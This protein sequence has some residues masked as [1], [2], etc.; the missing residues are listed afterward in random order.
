MIA[1]DVNWSSDD[2]LVATIHDG[3]VVAVGS[4][5]T[6]VYGEYQGVKLSCIVR[7]AESVGKA[8]EGISG[9]GDISESGGSATGGSATGG[10]SIS[11]VDVSIKV[12]EKFSLELKDANGIAVSVNW[13]VVDGSVCS[14]SGNVVTGL[15]AGTTT[16]SVTHE[17]VTYSCIVRV[18]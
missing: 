3:I 10:Y 4:G 7:C 15:T 6:T 9:S 1:T 13:T 2:E 5:S 12:D 16:V 11:H 14:V 8:N 18:Y 17:D